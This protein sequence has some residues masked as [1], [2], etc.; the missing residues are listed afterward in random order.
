MKA[1]HHA[2]LIGNANSCTSRLLQEL[3]K[4]ADFILAAD[5]GANAALKAGVI[6]H[7]I[8]GD[9]DSVSAKTKARLK[10]SQWLSAPDQNKTDFKK[11]MDFLVRQNCR[12]CTLVGFIGGRVDFSIGNMLAAYPYASKMDICLTADGWNVYPLSK[13]KRFTAKPGARVSLIPLKTCNGVTLSGLKY[14]LQ[15]ARLSLGTTHTISNLTAKK[16]FTVQMRSGS[17]L[18]CV[19]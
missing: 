13:S 2:L 15:D 5:G 19:E 4:K 17:L 6:P 14:P 10:N 1:S 9:F 7:A 12:Q 3:A 18:V 16:N 11:A 8:I